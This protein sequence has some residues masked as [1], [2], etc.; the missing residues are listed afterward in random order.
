MGTARVAVA[1]IAAAAC[2]TPARPPAPPPPPPAPPRDVL[3]AA[4]LLDDVAWL[5]ADARAGRGVGAGTAATARWLEAE[6][7][8]A[9]LTVATQTL[10]SPAGERNVIATWPGR[11]GE[12]L[13]VVAH[14]DHL[15]VVDG[16]VYPGADDNASGVAVAL[17]VARDLGRRRHLARPIVF[18]FPAAE[19]LGLHGA[20][21][22]AEQPAWP[23]EQTRAVVNL[24]MVGRRFF[25]LAVDRDA[26]V[27]AVGL[28][29]DAALAAAT[30]RAAARVGVALVRASPALLLAVGQ[31]YRGDDW[32]L[33]SGALPALHLSTGLHDDYHQPSDT[34]ARLVPAQ[35]ERVAR[36]VSA[37]L[38]ELDAEV[39]PEPRPSGE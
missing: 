27:G 28:G 9:G 29:D 24:D 31:A 39:T 33:R 5:T 21:A 4:A 17:A 18:L 15:G 36:L 14:Y 23:L 6:L 32:A 19:E 12:A 22:Y 11:G 3:S 37:I 30:E 13:L 35:L 38:V 2:G 20:R 16:R 25:E 8:A 1:F 26:A 10:A 7:A 34:A